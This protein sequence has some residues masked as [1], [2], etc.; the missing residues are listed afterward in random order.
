MFVP[1]IETASVVD[2]FS[3]KVSAELPTDELPS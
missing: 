2:A 1:L 3:V